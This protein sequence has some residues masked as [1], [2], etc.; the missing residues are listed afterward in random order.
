MTVIESERL[1]NLPIPIP[2]PPIAS[3]CERWN[4]DEIALFGSIL[5]DDFGADSD[6]DVMV[7][8]AVAARP[9]LFDLIQMQD[10]LD[11]S[12]NRRVDLIER[13]G[14]EQSTNPII[15]KSILGSAR[16]IYAR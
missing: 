14:V 15:R 3:F 16:V 9:S 4:V 1:R 12:L 7:T 13:R 5:T 10:E 8:F 2:L 6:V 11:A